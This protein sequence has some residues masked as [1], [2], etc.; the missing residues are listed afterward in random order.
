MP[1]SSIGTLAFS[2]DLDHLKWKAKNVPEVK[3]FDSQHFNA[4][5]IQ[6]GWKLRKLLIFKYFKTLAKGTAILHI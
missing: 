5:L 2:A 6:V 4:N 3:D 1:S